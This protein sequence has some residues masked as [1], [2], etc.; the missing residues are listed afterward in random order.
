MV[1][2]DQFLSQLEKQL[3]HANVERWLRSLKII[4]FDAANL[5]LEAEDSF[6]I[7]WFEEHVRPFIKS[8]INPNYR[9]IKIHL[10]LNNASSLSMK[11]NPSSPFHIVPDALDPEMTL[12]NFIKESPSH[13]VACDLMNE[14]ENPSFNPIFLYG[15]KGCGKTHLLMAAAHILQTKKSNIFYVSAHHFTDHVVQAIRKGHLPK[16]R[17]VYRS[18]GALL[19]D[20][21]HI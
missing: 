13:K 4:R 5:Y 9:P 6:Q 8:F 2:W 3:G 21:V 12:S 10:S 17:S 18:V 20:D 1:L 19:I 11:E 16:L 15:P 7:S 14:L